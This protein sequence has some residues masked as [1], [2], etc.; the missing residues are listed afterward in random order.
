LTGLLSVATPVRR[1]TV[2]NSLQAYLPFRSSRSSA[3]PDDGSLPS[4]NPLQV[5]NIRL[6][7]V[8]RFDYIADAKPT[9]P[10]KW[11]MPTDLDDVNVPF[12][13][14]RNHDIQNPDILTSHFVGNRNRISLAGGK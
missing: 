9:I 11:P 1:L 12:V 7:P 2:K 13:V 4:V 5:E 8:N 3:K 10:S 6:F 14:F